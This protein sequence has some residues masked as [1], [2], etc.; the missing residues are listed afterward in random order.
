MFALNYG[1]Q[2]NFGQLTKIGKSYTSYLL[3]M[4]HQSDRFTLHVIIL[5]FSRNKNH[6]YFFFK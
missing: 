1:V 4:T 6:C 2:L 3:I 5:V